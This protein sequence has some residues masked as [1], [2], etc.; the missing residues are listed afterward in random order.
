MALPEP[1]K[2]IHRHTRAI[3][4]RGYEREDGLWDIEG[5]IS[6]HKPEHYGHMDE[7]RA[8][9]M[10]HKMWIRMTIDTEFLIHD[11]AAWS[12]ITPYLTCQEVAPNFKALIGLRI[13]PG[14]NRKCKERVG[15][16]R[17]CTHMVEL[18]PQ[19]ATTAMQTIWPLRFTP[20]GEKP[21]MT[22]GLLNT[23]HSWA[24]YSPVVAE[25]FPENYAGPR[26]ERKAS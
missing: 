11:V 21:K 17:G 3:D 13:G 8:D 7:R 20:P 14:F 24:D 19:M 4:I 10:V 1:V 15:G 2:R 25:R 9:G 6:D 23:C 26:E 12:E 18:L 22:P 5:V 16:T